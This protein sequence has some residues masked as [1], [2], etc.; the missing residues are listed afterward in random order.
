MPEQRTLILVLGMHRSGTSVLTRVLNLLGADL[1][2]NL[3]QAQPDINA[4]GFWEHE[5]LIA[6]NE[7]LLGALG[8][9]WYDFHP[10]PPHWWAGDRVS[11]LMPRAVAFLETAFAGASLAAAKDPRLCLLL[12]FWREAARLAGWKPVVILA[13]RAPGE[14]VASLCRRDPLGSASANLL[15]LRYTRDSEEASRSLPRSCVDYAAL[16]EDWRTVLSR[17]AEELALDWPQ[18]VEAAADTVA[19]EIDPGL[20]HQCSCPEESAGEIA[21]RAARAYHLLRDEKL[22]EAG[23]DVVWRDFDCLFKECP[24]L[25]AGLEEANQR[26]FAVNSDLQALGESH[27]QALDVVA[28]K[29][30]QLEQLASELAHAVSVVTER[31]QQ[32]AYAQGIVEERDGQLQ[33]MAA[34]LEHAG[35]IVEMRDAQL[36]HPAV[37]ILRKLLFLDK[38]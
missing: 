25:A 28:A 17:V 7:A 12:P 10:L 23:L 2:T 5:E 13:T 27:Q 6:I 21:A 35:K 32:L 11:A 14:V 36:N 31:D 3:L 20:R 22:D 4:R 9:S 19:S 38:Q 24:S 18:A 1:G 33:R 30:Q 34:E 26:L 29:D 37:K 15:W 16:L 8:R